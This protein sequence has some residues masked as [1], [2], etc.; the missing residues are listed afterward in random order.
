MVGDGAEAG[1]RALA[2]LNSLGCSVYSWDVVWKREPLEAIIY[3]E[4]HCM[5]QLVEQQLKKQE[6]EDGERSHSPTT[7]M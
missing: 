1:R 3:S 6:A 5:T 4:V 7:I 2:S